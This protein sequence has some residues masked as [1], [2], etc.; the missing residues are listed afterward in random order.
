MPGPGYEKRMKKGIR[1][2]S[3]D[4]QSNREFR[5]QNQLTKLQTVIRN[6]NTTGKWYVSSFKCEL[7]ETEKKKRERERHVRQASCDP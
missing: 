5:Q 6:I 4:A 2:L 3:Q 1:S 7:K